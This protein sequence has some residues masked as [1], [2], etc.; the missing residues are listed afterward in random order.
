M[1]I[2]IYTALFGQHTNLKEFDNRGVPCLCFT[3]D[4]ELTSNTWTII[5]QPRVGTPRMD[6][7]W[8]KLNPDTLGLPL[9]SGDYSIWIDASIQ[10]TDID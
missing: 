7:K 2:I 6:A 9:K 10:I 5:L 8:P 1:A 3:D 4:P